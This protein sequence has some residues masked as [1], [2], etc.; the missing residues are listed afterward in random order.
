MDFLCHV[1]VSISL[2]YDN[3][4][5]NFFFE[6]KVGPTNVWGLFFYTE[7]FRSTHSMLW[8][9]EEYVTCQVFMQIARYLW[10]IWLIVR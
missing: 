4:K 9:I 10:Q 1:R 7:G 2:F 3:S 5:K 6:K 8:R